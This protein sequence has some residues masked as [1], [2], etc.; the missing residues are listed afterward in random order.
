MRKI[1]ILL[2]GGAFCFSSAV[3]AENFWKNLSFN[4]FGVQIGTD[5]GGAL[6]TKLEFIPKVFRPYPKMY[7][8]IGARTSI[9]LA[10][11]WDLG[12]EANYKTVEMSADA[13][14]ENQLAFAPNVNIETGLVQ[15]Y[16][17]QYF[18]G[19]ATMNM[20]FTM[21]EIPL[22]A[23]YVFPNGKDKIMFG[24]YGAWVMRATFVTDP[25]IGYIGFEPDKVEPGMVFPPP[26]EDTR[27]DFSRFTSKWDAGITFGYERELYQR[28]NIGLRVYA[29]FKDIFQRDIFP[30]DD[31]VDKI[32]EYNMTH[33]RGSLTISYDLF[34]T[35]SWWR[36]K[37]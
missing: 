10:P 13:L 36:D 5:V 1:V 18:S 30:N 3:S 14:V 15:G 35:H 32:L 20:S 21:L 37:K 12:L 23:K 26:S 6:P 11:G 31:S 17:K 7:M 28:I 33:M 2:I 22:Y 34:R 9:S 24:G 16:L 29:G 19:Q 8:S 4:T 27:M 25:Q